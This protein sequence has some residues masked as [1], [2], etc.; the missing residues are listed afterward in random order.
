[1]IWPNFTK[2]TLLNKQQPRELYEL[3]NEALAI[4][5]RETDAHDLHQER[6]IR[7]IM[8]ND[9]VEYREA[10]EKMKEMFMF[11]R[12]YS[13]GGVLPFQ[14]G[15][16]ATTM[17]AVG[18]IFLVFDFE[19]AQKFAD[20]VH[21]SYDDVPEAIATTWGWSPGGWIP[22]N[23]PKLKPSWPDT[24]AWTWTWMEPM[25]GTASFVILCM[26]M[27]RNQMKKLVIKPYTDMLQSRRAN[28]LAREYPQYTRSIVKDFG[29]SQPFRG[30]KFNP[31]GK[32]W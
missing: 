25:I 14:L 15:L 22:G 21:A 28:A 19:L 12:R 29:R 2:S 31:I 20:A 23:F 6:L 26:Q 7:D 13:L 17:A 10:C 27:G 32:T 11:N 4:A 30:D 9:D 24:G 3:S 18:S 1:M 16:A 5:A 8:A